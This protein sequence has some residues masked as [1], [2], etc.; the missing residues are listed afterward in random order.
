MSKKLLSRFDKKQIPGLPTARFEGRIVEVRS[1]A[2]A[3]ELKH[4]ITI[5]REHQLPA[6]FIEANGS[7]SAA[8]VIARETGAGLYTLDMAMSGNSYFDAMYR[9]IDTIKE[10]LE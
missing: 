3:M 10:A 5:T 1:E 2:S 9:N 8:E 7:C 4:L 6:I